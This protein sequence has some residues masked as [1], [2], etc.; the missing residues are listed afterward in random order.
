M[1]LAYHLVNKSPFIALDGKQFLLRL[2]I[3]NMGAFCASCD[4]A[5]S[6][7][8]SNDARRFVLGNDW[9]RLAACSG[10]WL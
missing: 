3:A 9:L 2:L 10:A 1:T 7:A 5:G 4:M 6:F 8:T